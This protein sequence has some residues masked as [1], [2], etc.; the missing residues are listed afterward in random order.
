MQEFML[1]QSIKMH[2]VPAPLLVTASIKKNPFRLPHKKCI[3]AWKHMGVATNQEWLIV[4][5]VL[6]YLKFAYK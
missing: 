3:L 4:A 2:T 1:D 5:R 6:R